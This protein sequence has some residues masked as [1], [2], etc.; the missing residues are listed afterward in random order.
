MFNKCVTLI[1]FVADASSRSSWRSS[2]PFRNTARLRH[3]RHLLGRSASG[4]FHNP[5][6]EAFHSDDHGPNVVS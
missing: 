1:Y 5:S 4:P 2:S 3:S 6:A